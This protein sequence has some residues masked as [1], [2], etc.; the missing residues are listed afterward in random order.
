MNPLKN[1][2]IIFT[3]NGPGAFK[4][5]APMLLLSF[6]LAGLIIYADYLS[7]TQVHLTALLLIPV[8]FASWYS[9]LAGGLLVSVLCSFSLLVDPLLGRQ[10]DFRLLVVSWNIL[11]LLVFF[12]SIAYLLTRLRRELDRA[13]ETARTDNL[14]GLL[15]TRAFFE[16]AESE[17][18]RAIRY[19]HPLTLCFLDLD[20]FKQV[21]DN[22]GHMT[23]DE[24]LR[25]VAHALRRNIRSNDIAVRLGGDEFAVLFPETGGEGE[26]LPLL[27][28]LQASVNQAIH[29]RGWTVTPSMGVVTFYQVP[30]DVKEL[31]HEADQRMYE[32][33]RGGKNRIV[34]ASVG[35]KPDLGE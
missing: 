1:G 22:L 17:R 28:K 33:K 35:S 34:S 14:T 19:G 29:Q 6:S 21:N 26:L 2:G 30:G 10:G 25:I 8:Y 24:L 18:V 15:N 31:L 3:M 4:Q 12:V 32:A 23:G 7:G 20:N 9:G 13:L 16:V 27:E 5:G 11:V